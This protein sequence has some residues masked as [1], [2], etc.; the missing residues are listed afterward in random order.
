M[1]EEGIDPDVDTYT[2]LLLA[3]AGAATQGG[4]DLED[5]SRV[6]QAMGDDGCEAYCATY[7]AQPTS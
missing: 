5:A 2:A 7:G 6:L 1:R 3:V 4:A